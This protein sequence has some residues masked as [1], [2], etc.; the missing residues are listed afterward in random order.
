MN[1]CPHFCQASPLSHYCQTHL[2][3]ACVGWL[4]GWL[5]G[6]ASFSKV[7]KKNAATVNRSTKQVGKTSTLA[8]AEGNSTKPNGRTILFVNRQA[9]GREIGRPFNFTPQ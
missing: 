7:N 2:T 5:V 9:G 6:H 4:V 3:L 8:G 1:R